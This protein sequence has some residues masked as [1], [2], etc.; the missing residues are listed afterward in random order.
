[1]AQTYGEVLEASFGEVFSFLRSPKCAFVDVGSGYGSIVFA[2]AQRGCL[3]IG[4]GI[5]LPLPLPPFPATPLTH[6]HAF[7]LVC[8]D[9][10]EF[11]HKVHALKYRR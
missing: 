7:L 9:G 10:M 11:S 4:I 8:Q 5:C 1:M 6:N 3:S 2:A